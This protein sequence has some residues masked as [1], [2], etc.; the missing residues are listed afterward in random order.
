MANQKSPGELV[1]WRLLSIRIDPD[2]PTPVLYSLV[3]EGEKDRPLMADGKIVFFTDAKRAESILASYGSELFA[4]E[5]AVEEPF[6]K[7]DLACALY[8]VNTEGFDDGAYVLNTVNTLW[9]LVRAIP[10]KMP[11]YHK[12]AFKK[13][14]AFGTLQRDLS[15]HF[16]GSASSIKQLMDAILWCVGAVVVFSKVIE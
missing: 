15:V 12:E 14:V 13:Y 9:D 16:E 11:D 2:D 3:L 4:D 10:M 8:L 6:F 7:I 5:V 1:I